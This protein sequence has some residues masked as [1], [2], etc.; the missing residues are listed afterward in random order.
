MSVALEP[1][2]AL[3]GDV[4]PKV[5]DGTNAVDAE[6]SRRIRGAVRTRSQE[7]RD[8]HPILRHQDAIGAG[9]LG[10]SVLGVVAVGLAHVA[11]VV[12]WWASVPVAAFFMAI[13]HEIEHDQI[14]RLYFARNAKAQN[15]M[16]AV[17]WALRPYTISPWSRRPLHLLHHKV[18]GTKRDIEERAITNGEPWGPKRALM[19][20]DPLAAS[21]LRMPKDRATRAP[22]L[23]MVAKAYFPM[24]YVALAIWYSFLAL[25]AANL[26]ARTLGAGP[27]LTAGL[28][29]TALHVI[30][31]LAIVWIAPN[32][33]RVACLHFVS[34]NMH[35]YGDVEEGNIVQQ[36]QVLNRW[37]LAPLQVFCANFGSTHS[38][39]HF[40]PSDPFY[41]RQMTARVVHP[42]MRANGVRFNDLGTLRRS[43][44][45]ALDAG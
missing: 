30:N 14:H 13:A 16:F 2:I 38:I 19:M 37:Y 26:V 6:R 22:Y 33:L 20:I 21:L 18:S 9:L 41:V 27:I 39:H 4:E 28:G 7:I 15:A 43:N 29:A 45:Y 35:Y 17:C 24:A 5:E 42:I 8:Q 23:K 1:R 36:T 34:S 44:R 31:V 3:P 12:P 11:G 40:V 25:N 32:V 10:V